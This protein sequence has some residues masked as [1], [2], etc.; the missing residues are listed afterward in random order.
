MVSPLSKLAN[1]WKCDAPGCG[2]LRVNDANH[3]LVL[4]AHTYEGGTLPYI[5]ITPW[6]ENYA[7]EAGSKHACGIQCAMKLAGDLVQ[8][9]FFPTEISTERK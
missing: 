8:K 7:A 2:V 1:P 4:K 6:N 3:W 9:N 5:V